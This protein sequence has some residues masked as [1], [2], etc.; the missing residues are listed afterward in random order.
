MANA[1]D[2]KKVLIIDDSFLIRRLQKEML[3]KNNL[4]VIEASNGQEALDQINEHGIANI[5]MVSLDLVMPVMNGVE[6]LVKAKGLFSDLPPLL[7]CSSKSD[8]TLIKQLAA[9]GIKGYLIKPID[10]VQYVKKL[11]EIFP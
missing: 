1:E 11:K 7:I 4:S 8:L 10:P 9:F 6:F 2:K 5:A 3:E